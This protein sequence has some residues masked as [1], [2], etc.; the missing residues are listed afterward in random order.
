MFERCLKIETDSL[1]P[2]GISKDVEVQCV[3]DVQ[4]GREGTVKFAFHPHQ[5]NIRT[6][7]QAACNELKSEARD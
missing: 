3:S 6:I 4:K 2:I 7:R 1:I 5:T